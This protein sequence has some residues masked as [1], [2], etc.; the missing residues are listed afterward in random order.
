MHE[1]S[2]V[3]AAALA[4][5]ELNE[6]AEWRAAASPAPGRFAAASRPRP[7]PSDGLSSPRRRGPAGRKV[8]LFGSPSGCDVVA[9][10][11]ADTLPLGGLERL[12]AQKPKGAAALA[13]TPQGRYWENYNK[14]RDCFNGGL[15]LA[16]EDLEI[17][18]KYA[19]YVRMF[20][21]PRGGWSKVDPRQRIGTKMIPCH[22]TD[23][24]FLNL[25]AGDR[26]TRLENFSV[27]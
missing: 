16:R 10:F 15:L 12:W 27:A 17:R 13:A 3:A 5:W 24:G 7:R 6:T 19:R 26:W 1:V 25:A 8:D 9:Y 23:Q 11:D 18:H 14:K 22:G 21:R 2:G 20:R 4:G